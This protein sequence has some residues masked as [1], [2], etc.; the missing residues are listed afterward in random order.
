MK[1]IL[2]TKSIAEASNAHADLMAANIYACRAGSRTTGYEVLV[3]DATFA[4]AEKVLKTANE[5]QG[6]QPIAP[7]ANHEA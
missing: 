3:R 4:E 1:T 7:E 2:V 5:K 6:A